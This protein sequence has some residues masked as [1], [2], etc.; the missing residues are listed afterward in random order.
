MGQEKIGDRAADARIRAPEY[1]SK[2][3]LRALERKSHVGVREIEPQGGRHP[4]RVTPL[5]RSRARARA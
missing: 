2:P 3:H 4:P 5:R 1:D